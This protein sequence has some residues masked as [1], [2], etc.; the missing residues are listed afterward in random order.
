VL[1]PGAYLRS[2][3]H[4]PSGRCV[5]PSR[6]HDRPSRPGRKPKR[7]RSP[8]VGATHS[9]ANRL[10]PPLAAERGRSRGP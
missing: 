8:R 7:P 9:Q 3:S 4:P 2:A 1:R 6:L 10:P 5:R